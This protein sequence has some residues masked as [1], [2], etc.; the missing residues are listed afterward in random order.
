VC[1]V[2]HRFRNSDTNMLCYSNTLKPF[3]LRRVVLSMGDSQDKS[4]LSENTIILRCSRVKVPG[5]FNAAT[6]LGVC[7]T[8]LFVKRANPMSGI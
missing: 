8:P 1:C 6:D 4:V 3:M 7:E 5:G 2:A